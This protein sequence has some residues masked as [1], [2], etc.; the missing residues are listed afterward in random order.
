VNKSVAVFTSWLLHPLLMPT[1]LFILLQAFVPGALT[2]MD[3][4]ISYYLLLLIFITTCIIP[5]LSLLGLRGAASISNIRLEKRKERLLPFI[6]ITVFYIVTAYMFN[7]RLNLNP[8][9]Q[10]I[11]LSISLVVLILTLLTF[12][13]KISIHSAGVGGTTAVFLA[14][15]YFFPEDGLYRPVCLMV[16][17]SG[18]TLTSRLKLNAHT[19]MEIYAGF[20]TGFIIVFS[21]LILRS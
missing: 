13:W 3:R 7:L 5:V 18:I 15:S 11:F 2:P 4:S 17:I 10:A 6:F 9:L 8:I 12:F 1:Y 20:C 16:L 14:L 19:P 21:M